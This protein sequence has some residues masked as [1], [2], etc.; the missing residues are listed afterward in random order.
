MKIGLISLGCAK[1]LVDSEMILGLLKQENNEIVENIINADAVI[2][3]CGFIQDAKKESIAA[4]FD[5]IAKKRKDAFLVVV[6]CL[7]KRYKDTLQKEIPEIDLIIGVDEYDSFLSLWNKKIKTNLKGKLDYSHR[8]ISSFPLPFAYLKIGE[9]CSNR[10]AYCAIP[11]IR[12][13]Y[14][15]YPKET[16]IAEAQ[17]LIDSG[18]LEIVIIAQDTTRYG[19]DRKSV[20]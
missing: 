2:N 4:I 20:V 7:A 16:I 15:S 6:G 1:N 5:V 13:D 18:I 12:G 8:L 3:T 14:Y 11:L 9:G 10:C 17:R 19:K